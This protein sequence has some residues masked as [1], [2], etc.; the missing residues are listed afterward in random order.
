MIITG[1]IVSIDLNATITKAQGGT[2]KG[3]EIVFKDA[4][5]KVQTKNI[6]ENGLK[7]APAVKNGLESLEPGDNFTVEMEKK[8]DF[9][10][11]ISIKKGIEQEEKQKT[12]TQQSTTTKSTSWET[13]EERAARQKLIVRQSSLTNAVAFLAI[14]PGTMSITEVD[15]IETATTFYNWVFEQEVDEN[16]GDDFNDGVL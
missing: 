10:T 5:G 11:W 12:N 13:A 1:K 9:W 8:D 15:V 2:Y 3:A 14:Q 16:A 7:Y 6:H 4:T